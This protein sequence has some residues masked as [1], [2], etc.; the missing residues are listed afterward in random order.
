MIEF[1]TIK[2]KNFLS[3]GNSFTELDLKSHQ[4]SLM[5]GKNGAGKST[6]LD[7]L[8][9]VLFGK[10]FRNINKNLLINSINKKNTMVEVVFNIGSSQ[11]K[12]TRGIKPNVFEIY[13]NDQLI[14][15]NAEQKEYQEMLEKHILKLNHK[16]FNQVVV[17]GSASF[18]PFMQLTA[19]S[20]REIIEDILDIE[21][22]TKMNV[23]LKE[24]ISKN[25]EDLQQCDFD[26]KNITTK[27]SIEQ[28]HLDE[29]KQ[30][31]ETNIDDKSKQKNKIKRQIAKNEKI[32]GGLEEQR[33]QLELEKTYD[34][35]IQKK[36][37][38]RVLL[39]NKLE[40]KVKDIDSDIEFFQTNDNCPT[41]KQILNETFK[42]SS[43]EA[44]Q[45]QK[46]EYV[47]AIEKLDKEIEG[48][49]NTNIDEID[50]KINKICTEILQIQ[51]T[52]G[53]DQRVVNS[54]DADI[55]V[56]KEDKQVSSVT[57]IED[58]TT[59]LN[60]KK[61]EY[62]KLVEDKKLL[63]VASLLLKD[64]GIKTR[65]I[66]QYIPVMNKLINKYLAA[67]D[68]FVNFELNE[69]FEET[70]KSR[71]RDE[72]VYGSFSEGEKMRIDLALLFTWRA[73]AKQRNSI[74][75]N[76]LIM[77]EVFDSSLD[78]DGVEEFMKILQQLT[79]GNNTFI[80]SHKGD[81]LFDKFENVIKFEKVKNFSRIMQ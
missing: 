45:Q 12:I 50:R 74:A 24:K 43:V 58:L 18:V 32:L 2:W 75:T 22:F 13:C 63:E 31:I 53:V 33:S 21:I 26:V 20:R 17:L 7:A 27:I 4:L 79:K 61:Q 73:I 76:I 29:K 70:I 37:D 16:S 44:K 30:N 15:Q 65:I 80:I 1:S 39:K 25:K 52:I 6:F 42:N 38:K 48:F 8:S 66:R 67:M 14:D 59:S 36:I 46:S 68:F 78:G 71:F 23:L 57:E 77:D 9:F 11:Y 69:N 81:Q 64:S 62:Q 55:R 47:S 41:C 60:E 10:P 54:I 5:V 35:L 19:A 3:T 51:M 49:G 34:D 28:K 72:F 56:L 40:Q